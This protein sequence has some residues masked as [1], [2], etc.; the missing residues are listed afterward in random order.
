M[1]VLIVEHIYTFSCIFFTHDT[2]EMVPDGAII[3]SLVAIHNA[4]FYSQRKCLTATILK[5]KRLI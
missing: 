5:K 3:I 2:Y 1:R 4:D